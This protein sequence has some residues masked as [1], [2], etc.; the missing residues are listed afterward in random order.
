MQDNQDLGKTLKAKRRELG[1][2][3]DE[4]AEKLGITKYHLSDIERGVHKLSLTV[5][6]GYCEALNLTPNELLGI[7]TLNINPELLSVLSTMDADKQLQVLK[8]VKLL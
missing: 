7:N 5:F 6:L 4:L 2:T 3:Q 8:I 1:I